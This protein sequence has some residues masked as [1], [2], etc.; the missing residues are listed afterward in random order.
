MK[1]IQREV[2]SWFPSLRIIA[3]INLHYNLVSAFKGTYYWL[4]ESWAKIYLT[5]LEEIFAK[6]KFKLFCNYVQRQDFHNKL[7]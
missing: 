3:V 2:F 4:R 6:L 5:I 1:L 7:I